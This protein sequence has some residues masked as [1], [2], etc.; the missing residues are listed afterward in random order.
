MRFFYLVF[1]SFILAVGCQNNAEN[2]T[3]SKPV[4]LSDADIAKGQQLY[5]R[6]GCA[7][8]HGKTGRGD[9]QIARTL[10]PRPRDFHKPGD[11]KY[12][13]SIEAILRTIEKGVANNRGTGMPGYPH[14]PQEERK[15]IAIFIV[16]LQGKQ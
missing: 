11:Y 13:R 10:N 15:A 14:L 12:G 6:Y 2:N 7:V 8:C 4:P 16:S 1:A 3:A 9:G 5:K